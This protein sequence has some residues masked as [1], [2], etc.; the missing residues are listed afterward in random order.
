MK[1]VL[2]L[3]HIVLIIMFAVACGGTDDK[4]AKTQETEAKAVSEEV[5][6]TENPQESKAPTEPAEETEV[7]EVQEEQTDAVDE[8]KVLEYIQI[9]GLDE[10][11]EY[12]NLDY[13]PI[14]GSDEKSILMDINGID[15]EMFDAAIEAMEAN[16]CYLVSDIMRNEEK[17]TT[18]M[19]YRNADD[20]L[21][22]E[23]MY[24]A[25][26]EYINVIFS[27]INLN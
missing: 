8:Q 13:F 18:S 17:N 11:A 7:Q 6:P 24:S 15:G 1:K 10:S 14:E 5:V 2:V 16:G 3:I 9:F 26:A 21:Y 4:T 23:L 19:Q 22:I 25:D 20:S 12:S 27:P